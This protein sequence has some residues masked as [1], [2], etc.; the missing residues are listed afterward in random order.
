MRILRAVSMLMF[1]VGA[2][3]ARDSDVKTDFDPAVDFTRFKTFS[4]I[5]GQEMGRTG[6][7]SNPKTRERIK[8]FIGGVMEGRGLTEVPR[9][10]KKELG[11]GFWGGRG[12]KDE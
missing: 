7:L 6:L 8:N 11:G 5:G 1:C 9:E 4:F 3:I 12:R 2:A 10:Q